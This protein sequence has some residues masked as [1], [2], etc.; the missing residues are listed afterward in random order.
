MNS[1]R[2]RN[3]TDLART[4]RRHLAALIIPVL[5]LTVASATALWLTPREYRSSATLLPESGKTGLPLAIDAA[6]GLPAIRQQITDR[7]R[8]VKLIESFDLHREAR[9]KG[10]EGDIN[11]ENIVSEVRDQISVESGSDDVQEE[12]AFTISFRA[13]DPGTARGVTEKIVDQIV[14]EGLVSSIADA[15]TEIDTLR[16]R[17]VE[18]SSKLNE[19]EGRAALNETQ[20]SSPASTIRDSQPASQT[21]RTQLDL[22]SLKDQLNKLGQQIADLNNRIAAQK[23][24]VDDM[25]KG[26]SLS[27]NPTYALLITKRTELQG[28]RDNL[29]NRQEL[30]EKHPRVLAITD[31][32]AAINNQIEELR[33]QQAGRL[34]Q[35]PEARELLTLEADRRRLQLELEFTGREIKRRASSSPPPRRATS[36]A[37]VQRKAGSTR[38]TQEYRRLERDLADATARLQAAENGAG[39]VRF[40][41]LAAAT[42]PGRSERPNAALIILMAAAVGLFAGACLALGLG[43]RRRGTVQAP[44]D[45]EYYTRLPLLA[46][47]P[48]STTV[49]ER[50]RLKTRSRVLLT[51]GVAVAL[52]STVALTRLL[53]ATEV[54][55]LI[56][57]K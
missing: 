40:R 45:V 36:P 27:D 46:A 22:E 33:K 41:V 18:L 37:P 17:T 23:Q 30:T 7:D 28:Q 21:W 57:G 56:S 4:A 32:I 12:N 29:I 39:V 8:I 31:Q 5:V 51:A 48:K 47:I 1:P 38:F 50:R 6:R 54:L 43:S 13:S 16:K 35:T 42:L 3:L 14:A 19:L 10:I 34:S 26:S 2:P 24:I 44:A 11:P 20:A 53:L 9:A 52:L 49:E 15:R 25:K 55:T